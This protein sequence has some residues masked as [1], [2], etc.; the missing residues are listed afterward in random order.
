M[1]ESFITAHLWVIYR[2]NARISWRSF[3]INAEG[4]HL[5]VAIA[6]NLHE[7]QFRTDQPTRK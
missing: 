7:R 4:E 2:T 1:A 3:S 6:T 5:P